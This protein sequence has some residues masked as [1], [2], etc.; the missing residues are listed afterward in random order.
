MRRN[1]RLSR[2]L[3]CCPLHLLHGHHLA[4]SLHD[5]NGEAGERARA[6][7]DRL[8]AIAQLVLIGGSAGSVPVI[9][10]LL[11]R[12]SSPFP[13]PIVIAL[14]QLAELD[15]ATV[16]WLE[17]STSHRVA[18]CGTGDGTH[19]LPLQP[20]RVY[21]ARGGHDIA[22]LTRGYL[23]ARSGRSRPQPAYHPSIDVLFA[24]AKV[25]GPAAIAILLSGMGSD[26]AAGMAALHG[27]GART[28]AQSPETCVVSAMPS[29]AIARGTARRV[30]A[31]SAI[32]AL[33][34][35]E[36]RE[37]CRALCGRVIG[38]DCDATPLQEP[39]PIWIEP[40]ERDGVWRTW[41]SAPTRRP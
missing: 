41:H 1:P 13:L 33:V 5:P 37:A 23:V 26:G 34:R 3:P 8:G 31:P 27:A 20:G 35:D 36:A 12:L 7:L 9:E 21:V 14:H 28:V 10:D 25:Y 11:A 39:A 24:S 2:D 17:T 19:V 30:M 4:A 6:A 40:E 15:Q 16:R 32:A 22:I 38:E 18:W 29:S